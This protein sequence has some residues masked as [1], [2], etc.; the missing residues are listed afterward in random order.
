MKMK[1]KLCI[2]CDTNK[3]IGVFIWDRFI[4]MDCEQEI[5]RTD[6]EDE[7]YTYFIH[8]MRQI[9]FKKEA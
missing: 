2:V 4:C 5:I 6:V 3:E 9:W 1:A 7:K 8:R